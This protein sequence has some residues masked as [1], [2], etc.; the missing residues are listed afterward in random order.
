M[1]GSFSK[2]RYRPGDYYIQCDLSGYKILRSEA[3]RMWDGK[4]VHKDWW[5]SRHPQ[6]FVRARRDRIAAPEPR[7]ENE[8]QFLST[9]EVKQTDL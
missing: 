8:D 2:D 4:I 1:S 9:N 7:P 3:R 6:E 5:E